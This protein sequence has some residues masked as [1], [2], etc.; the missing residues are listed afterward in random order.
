M[1]TVRLI[2]PIDATVV[3]NGLPIVNP[4]HLDEFF[5]EKAFVPAFQGVAAE[6]LRHALP[7]SVIIVEESAPCALVR[8][9]HTPRSLPRAQVRIVHQQHG[10]R[11]VS[12]A[13]FHKTF[14]QA[15]QR[16]F[17]L[18]SLGFFPFPCGLNVDAFGQ[19]GIREFRLLQAND[20]RLGPVHFL[21]GIA[22][23]HFPVA[24]KRH[25]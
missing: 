22:H 14:V 13:G 19:Y 20:S 6:I 24:D 18:Q 12:H 9:F 17:H 23:Q 8:K 3:A 25:V 11:V 1:R 21:V 5:F 16:V 2:Q 15:L 10:A 4:A 7:Q